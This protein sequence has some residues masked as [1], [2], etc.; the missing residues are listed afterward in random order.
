MKENFLALT[1]EVKSTGIVAILSNAS[2]VEAFKDAWQ[3]FADE[4]PELFKKVSDWAAEFKQAEAEPFFKDGEVV[5]D[6]IEIALTIRIAGNQ[7]SECDVFE[8]YDD[9]VRAL[10]DV[11]TPF[12]QAVAECV[13]V[14]YIYDI[15]AENLF[16]AIEDL[17]EADAEETEA[18]DEDAQGADET[19]AEEDGD[20]NEEEAET[21]ESNDDGEAEPEGE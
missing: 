15:T 11:E 21:D 5:E 6:A 1:Q 2:N 14:N 10:K 7:F 3:K 13:D 16:D 9:L 12:A 20:E 17:A 4:N 19:E 18:D 8:N